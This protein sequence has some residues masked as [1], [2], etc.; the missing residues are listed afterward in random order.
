[1]PESVPALAETTENSK[2]TAKRMRFMA[3]DY[4]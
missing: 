3:G 1:V 2:S 4:S